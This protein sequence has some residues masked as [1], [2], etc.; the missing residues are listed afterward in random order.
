MKGDNFKVAG[1][2]ASE[3]ERNLDISYVLQSGP[4]QGLAVRWRNVELNGDATGRRDE[5]R[6]ILAYTIPLR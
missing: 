6:L 1:E 2:D 4:L 3:W 5:N